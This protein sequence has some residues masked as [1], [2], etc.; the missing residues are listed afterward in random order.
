MSYTEGRFR[1]ETRLESRDPDF[2]PT[3]RFDTQPEAVEFI[4]TRSS[5]PHRLWRVMDT[6]TNTVIW[7]PFA[8]SEAGQEG[9]EKVGKKVKL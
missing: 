3:S 8:W 6:E 2:R 5:F 9:Q 4:R 7:G 1:V